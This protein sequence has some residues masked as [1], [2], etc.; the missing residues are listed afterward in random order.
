S[1]ESTAW[2][3]FEVNLG[4]LEAGDHTLII[5][6]Y[7]NKKTYYNESTEVLIDDVLLKSF[8]VSNQ[9]PDVD[10]G[11]DQ[12]IILPADT[13]V[14]DATCTDDGLPNGTLSF[15]WNQV[16]GPGTVTFGDAGAEDTTATFPA[17]GL[18]VIRL[19]ID[20]T[21]LSTSDDIQVT[22]SAEP[23]NLAP[24][25]NAGS[26]QTITLPV[27]NVL[28][29]ASVT[30]DGLPAGVLTTVWNQL[31]GPANQV[32]FDNAYVIKTTATFLSAGTYVLQ[33]VADDGELI[34]NDQ[35]DITVNEGGNVFISMATVASGS[36]DAEESSS[37]NM[38]LASR[39]LEMVYNRRNQTVGIRFNSIDIPQGATIVNAY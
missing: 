39:D 17:G 30:D 29:E 32:I 4:I 5:G 36:D 6:G 24:V 27:D 12:T 7:N 38:R 10:A 31:S 2:H 23:I 14:L 13:V 16:S 15:Q 37:G 3:L 28:L 18:Y 19:T 34:A 1:S 26:D 22:V 11:S 35:V 20:D 9:A 25:V 8:A 21:E 33:L